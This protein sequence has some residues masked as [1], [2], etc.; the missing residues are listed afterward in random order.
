MEIKMKLLLDTHILLWWLECSPKLSLNLKN[1]ISDPQNVIYVS[2]ASIWEISIKK[3]LGKLSVPDDLLEKV[4]ENRFQI[5]NI[6]PVH[7][8]ET[9]NL[10]YH[11]RDPFDRMLIA[12]AL[13]EG[14]T[15]ISNDTKFTLYDVPLF[16]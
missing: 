2:T 6:E 15:L 1:I 9:E 16:S 5:L 13:V 4:N 14:I 3:S 11:H 12:Q 10:P 7:A 8:I